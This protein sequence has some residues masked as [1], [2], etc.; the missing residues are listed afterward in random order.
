MKEVVIVEGIRTAIGKLG[1]SLI[2]ETA[3]ILGSTVIRELLNRTQLDPTLIDEVILGQAKQSADQSNVARLASLRAELPITVPGYTVHRQCGSGLQSINNA[4][5]QIALGY[6]DII[7]AGGTESMST[8]PYY[9][10]NARYGYGV[11][12]AVLLDPNTE[13]QPGSQPFEVYGISTMGETAENLAE[14]YSISREEQDAFAHRSQELTAKAIQEGYFDKQIVPY[15]VKKRKSIDIF[16]KDEHPFLTSK[17]KLS[18]LKPV[19]RKGGSV[20]AGN[21]SGRNDGA[22]ALLI[23]SN[24]KALELGYKPKVKIIAQAAAGVD[25]SIMGIGPVPATLKALKQ[26]NLSIQDIDIIELNEAF[27]AQSIAVINELGL[28]IDR[29]NPNGGA[30]AMGHPIGATGAIL[31]TKLIH[32]LE[33]TGKRYGLVTL[34]IAGGLGVSTIVENCQA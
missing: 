15:E 1:G 30:I 34:C 7:I 32:E 21:S 29:V 26:A 19:F 16:D 12:N 2:N 11:G 22:A 13:S 27:A 14:K 3:D 25:P 24:E 23:M 17:E 10:R 33:R 8:A 5:Q 20:T 28:D 18:T 9:L 4:A 6:S 31:M